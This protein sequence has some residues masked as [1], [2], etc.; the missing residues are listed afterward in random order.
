MTG[1][2]N[3]KKKTTL[4]L[5]RIDLTLYPL[6]QKGQVEYAWPL[7]EEK[8]VKGDYRKELSC[9]RDNIMYLENDVKKKNSDDLQTHFAPQHLQDL[10]KSGL[11]DE[12]IRQAGI[13]SVPPRDINKILGNGWFASQVN[14]LLEFK[15]NHG[16]NFA[17]HKLFPEIVDKQ[18]HKLKYFQ[19]RGSKPSLYLPPTVKDLDNAKVP[20][21][22]VEGEKKTL[23][24]WQEGF[25]CSVGLG[26]CWNWKD[27][28]SLIPKLIE[29]FNQIALRG[30]KVTIISDSDFGTNPNVRIGYLLLSGTLLREGVKVHLIVIPCRKGGVKQG[31]DDFLQSDHHTVKDVLSLPR[32]KITLNVL[33]GYEGEFSHL[34]FAN[35]FLQDVL[36]GADPNIFPEISEPLQ[37][38]TDENVQNIPMIKSILESFGQPLH[39]C[40]FYKDK[41]NLYV[42]G[43]NGWY[44]G[45][46]PE[47][48]NKCPACALEKAREIL[49]ELAHNFHGRFLYMLMPKN[50]G[51]G[52]LRNKILHECERLGKTRVAAK[53]V[54]KKKK[55]IFSPVLVD[56]HMRPVTW[57]SEE[58][59]E[60]LMQFLACEPS[61]KKGEHKFDGWGDFWIQDK[62]IERRRD[63][64]MK[65][66]IHLQL[67]AS[68]EEVTKALKDLGE[69]PVRGKNG[70]S[71]FKLS[72][73]TRDLIRRIASGGA[74]NPNK[75]IPSTSVWYNA[76][77]LNDGG[78]GGLD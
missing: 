9:M 41:T 12:T 50:A 49:T 22:I 16:S 46:H 59:K 78:L 72:P 31:L 13:H 23:R 60:L 42:H 34:K 28:Y 14:S 18:G 36:D 64:K 47:H 20:L 35:D 54:S 17:R 52:S 75:V 27:S 62:K 39:N 70:I 24:W 43:E 37:T 68:E 21:W 51:H 5:T 15:Y 40:R 56:S 19:K 33:R 76:K 53:L 71:K 77:V 44:E 38:K 6:H 29:D 1:L 45:G 48:T 74:P 3:P 58:L 4:K 11:K 66:V 7:G 63:R 32:I 2:L 10:R 67:N 26:G 73:T 8:Y 69:K 65:G 30:R 25:K 55:V 61:W 57:E